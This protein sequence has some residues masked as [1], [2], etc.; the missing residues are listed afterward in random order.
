MR[1]HI[2]GF[3]GI[4]YKH[5]DLQK[6]GF[7]LFKFP[8]EGEVHRYHVVYINVNLTNRCFGH[9]T[10]AVNDTSLNATFT[11]L[12]LVIYGWKSGWKSVVGRRFLNQIK[13]LDQTCTLHCL[14]R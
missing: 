12:V 8:G 11:P 2:I 7:N 3:I 9:P 13:T 1:I 5:H 4:S 14:F 10:Y 6:F